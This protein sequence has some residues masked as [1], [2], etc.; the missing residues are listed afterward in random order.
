[1][2]KYHPLPKI[3]DFRTFSSSVHI[4]LEFIVETGSTIMRIKNIV[5][6]QTCT[7]CKKRTPPPI[8][9]SRRFRAETRECYGG[10][11]KHLLCTAVLLEKYSTRLK[12]EG[13]RE[14]T[15][16]HR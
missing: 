11:R 4:E 13:R 1:M 12:T 2:L 14:K 8:H 7:A 16:L 9:T 5:Q 6:K 15:S 10:K 3:S